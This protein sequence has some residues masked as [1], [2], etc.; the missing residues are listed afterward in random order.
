MKIHCGGGVGLKKGYEGFEVHTM[1]TTFL[2]F[3]IR[4]KHLII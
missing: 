3:N 4:R 2:D 1:I